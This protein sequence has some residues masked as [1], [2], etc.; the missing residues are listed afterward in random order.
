MGNFNQPVYEKIKNAIRENIISGEIIA[1]SRLTI[2]EVAVKYGTSQ[3]PV[4]EALQWLQGEGLLKIIPHKGAIVRLIDQNMIKND[5]EIRVAIEIMLIN[6][7]LKKINAKEI[8][9]LEEKHQQLKAAVESYDITEILKKDREMHLSIYQYA[10]NPEAVR[11]YDRYSEFLGA[12]RLQYGIGTE[13]LLEIIVQH[14][15]II[16][17][18]AKKNISL[19]ERIVKLHS[20]HAMKDLLLQMHKREKRNS[21]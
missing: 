19:L 5:Y 2:K 8:I 15:E 6:K 3:M 4:R 14:K 7:S 9:Y 12:L 18:L 13:R 1:G 10:D 16:M 20:E 11:I 21:K 17:A